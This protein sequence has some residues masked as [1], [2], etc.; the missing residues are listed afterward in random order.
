[1]RLQRLRPPAEL[2]AVWKTVEQPTSIQQSTCAQCCNTELPEDA[3]GF[4]TVS[5]E[6]PHQAQR[7][8]AISAASTTSN[9]ARGNICRSG[10]LFADDCARTIRVIS[11]H[12]DAPSARVNPCPRTSI[13]SRDT[14][15]SIHSV[16]HLHHSVAMQAKVCIKFL[17]SKFLSS[18]RISSHVWS[19]SQ[20]R[21][22]SFCLVT[23]PVTRLP[24]DL[25]SNNTAT[26]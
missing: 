24:T 9:R 15:T 6:I 2:H 12:F 19:H 14:T 26:T 1:M 25:E 4:L 20:H 5:L 10:I 8:N 17:I 3:A 11:S 16:S 21:T 13:L 7:R 23:S 22:R 18:S